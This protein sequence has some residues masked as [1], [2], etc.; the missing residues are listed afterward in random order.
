[1]AI[2]IDNIVWVDKGE[3]NPFIKYGMYDFVIWNGALF[4]AKK[5]SVGVSPN[6][7]EYWELIQGI[8]ANS[9]KTGDIKN[10]AVTIL[11]GGTGAVNASSAME[12]LIG[13]NLTG[14][15]NNAGLHSSIYRGK[16]L[17]TEVTAAQYAAI[18]SGTFNDLWNGDYWTINGINYR[19]AAFDY[20][21]LTGDTSCETHHIVL[22]PDNIMY[23]SKMNSTE[24]TGVPTDGGTT[25][26][27][28]V[29]S[30]MYRGNV[31][32]T[33]T[34][35]ASETIPGLATAKETINAAFGSSHILSHRQYFANAANGYQTD[36]AWYDSTVELMTEQ[37][38]YGGKIYSNVANGTNIPNIYTID[39]SQYPLFTL[40]PYMISN[41]QYYWLRDV[42][43]STDFA[44]VSDLGGASEVGGAAALGVRPAFSICA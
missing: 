36:G 18:S 6:N 27:A 25:L 14:L 37:N 26:G 15:S 29:G 44:S 24:T 12:N 22:V 17:G 3:Y 39:K 10:G 16:Y 32:F 19:I 42:V 11:K 40:N 23:S 43:S 7:L 9:I 8:P 4:L 34:D 31:T 13:V 41:R 30:A 35:N 20:Y 33:N 21:Y 1:M 5:E 28:Y 38:V 2:T